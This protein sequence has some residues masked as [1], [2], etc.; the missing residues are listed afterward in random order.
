MK[1]ITILFCFAFSL[2]S[3]AQSDF[4]NTEGK[5]VISTFFEGF[6]KGDTA[7]MSSVMMKNMRL[8]SAYVLKNGKNTL[9]I[10]SGTDFLTAIANR[11]ADQV[12][13]ENLKGYKGDIDGNLAHIWA[14][15]EFL[16]N[17]KLSHCG[18]NSF[19]LV[20]TDQ[21]WKIADIVDSRRREGCE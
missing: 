9:A 2:N 13:T 20:K 12:W 1:L 16:I 4:F 18:V 6:H 17:G 19:T 15:Y 21:G 8:Q 14:P 3:Y 5:R 10:N 11:P 7:Q